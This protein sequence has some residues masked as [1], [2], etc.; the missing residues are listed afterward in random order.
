MCFDAVSYLANVFLIVES[1]SDLE[2]ITYKVISLSSP[3]SIFFV[4]LEIEKRDVDVISA[5]AHASLDVMVPAIRFTKTTNATTT[6]I[7]PVLKIPVPINFFDT[8]H[9]LF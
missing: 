9:L 5:V 8:F 4:S 3:F 1:A 7:K 6:A 2:A